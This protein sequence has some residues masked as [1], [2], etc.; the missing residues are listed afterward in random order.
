MTP[1][2]LYEMFPF[3][4]GQDRLATDFTGT[5]VVSA[6]VNK[7]KSQMDIT[8]SLERPIPPYEVGIMEDLLSAELDL[9]IVNVNTAI[10]QVVRQPSE[11]SSGATYSAASSPGGSKASSS[12]AKNAIMGRVTKVTPT[13][14]CDVNID[15]GKVTVRGE[16]CAERSKFNDKNNSWLLN[17][18]I[19]DHTSSIAV[20]KF[21]Q[22]EKAKNIVTAIKEGMY[23]TVSGTLVIS[24]FDGEMTLNP[25]NIFV[26]EKEIR[27]DKSEG[28]RVE[29]HL[30]T[31]MSAS[32]GL[33]DVHEVIS[34]AA[35]WGH[36][37]I[38]ITDHGIV[39]A[40]PEA[41]KAAAKL[42]GKI[43]VI[44]GMEGYYRNDLQDAETTDGSPP[45]K[46]RTNHII[47]LVKNETGLK[48]LYKLVTR[49]HL[50]NFN[51][52]PL[53]KRSELE[54][55]REGLIIG[56]ACERGEL[57]EAI[58]EGKDKS[59]LESIARFYDYLE[60]QP[61]CNNMFMIL[62]E[63]PIANSVDELRAFNRKVVEIGK[64][65]D[66]PVVATC[67]VHFLDPTDEI[68]RKIVMAGKGFK[69]AHEDLPLF[70]RT[71]EEM[72]DEFSY[73]G[74][75]TAY[76]LVVTNTN[77]IA[78]MCEAISPLP[79]KN[80]LFP[81]KLEGS[82]DELKKLIYSKIPELYGENP[83]QIVTERADYE[84]QDILRLN[85]DVIYMAAQKLV[86]YLREE[87][88][89]VG[90]RGSVGSSFVAYLAGITEVNPLPA[91]YRCPK[92]KKSEFPKT[93]NDNSDT[94]GSDTYAC[95]PNMPDKACTNCGT[96]FIK[97]GFNIPFETF[98]G[99]GGE[100]IPDIDLNISSDH[101]TEA[102]R[103]IYGMFGADHVYRAGT[104]GTTQGKNAFKVVGKYL[105]ALNITVP[106]AEL[107]RLASGCVGVKSTTG[108][109]PGGLIVIP[110]DMELCDFCPA[111]YPADDS[112]KGVI[113]LHFEYK[114]I[115][116]NLIKLDIL[117]HDNPTMLKMLEDITGID[118]DDIKL[119][120]PDT[121]SVFS[122]PCSL[123]LPEDDPVI[124]ETGSIGVPEFGTPF[125]RQMLV[126]TRP[127][128]FD[129]LVRLSGY[130]HGTNVWL[131]N[132][133]ELIATGKASVGETISSRDD[134]ML[135]LISK[136][137]DAKD[138]FK[139]SENVR[140]GY[141][142]PKGT[143]PNLKSL[144]V[145]PWYIDSC[146]KISYLFPKAHAVAYV[147]MAFRI[148]W[149]KVHK[150]LEYYSA[151]FYR[152]SQYGA[153]DA[154]SM[155]RGI[156]TVRARIREIKKQSDIGKKEEELL[157]TYESC[158]EFYMRG[159]S[160]AQID[161]YTSDAEKFL[162]V[163]D[164]QL[165]PPFI[166]I[167]G[168]GETA[169]L[170]LM[171]K[172]KGREFISISDILTACS[173]VNKN[174]IERLKSLGGLRDLPDSSQMSLF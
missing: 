170:D 140:K 84:L 60:I 145:P 112:D 65:L 70:Y 106:K 167:S 73:L 80:K 163:G 43:K 19:T 21:M 150:P 52:R 46:K 153:F 120:D 156:D 32:D 114:Y 109:H 31:K 34:R 48:N 111:Q 94:S 132:A 15:L 96:A 139:I 129:T 165:R 101:Q 41:A 40:F 8:L 44:Y 3:L 85:Y 171:E 146:N 14:M 93:H 115:E 98:M 108:Q 87:H 22:E 2:P 99:F 64:S 168:L 122:S 151:H 91:H 10:K 161:I 1:V 56:S 130:S 136:G 119:D 159:F 29:L 137:M 12:T 158:Y 113:T 155:I 172:R 131:G 68:F 74:E 134:I 62:G 125:V 16:V 88:S 166:S 49:S 57:F 69:S 54:Q 103:Y 116:D 20:R 144:H 58:T 76:E 173:S 126:D 59:E 4:K 75:D 154:Q 123:G 102:H 24:N 7:E 26:S 36:P 28:K 133:K 61:L 143:E 77:K 117:G 51:N 13:P 30:H 100:K 110:Q 39:Q 25:S 164:N 174:H 160:F 149:F 17:F 138:A 35:E 33:T 50:V 152:R 86:S 66:I 124:G 104:I 81:P 23:L 63:K 118:A 107:N 148:A 5:R 9:K 72:L 11:F 97:D 37:A 38:A 78:D 18:D 92:C 71:T 45:P 47:L 157:S 53:I 128:D 6:S 121:M 141:G 162:L 127:K 105:S 67:D 147:I 27:E 135:Y 82:A 142:L 79:P 83:P 42:N 89:R 55:F 90:S 169:A 95:G